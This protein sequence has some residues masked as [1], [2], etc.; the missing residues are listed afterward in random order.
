MNEISINWE[1]KLVNHRGFNRIA[2]YFE[3]NIAFNE[4][5][6]KIKGAKWSSSLKAWHIPDNIT[7][8][9]KFNLNTQKENPKINI[10]NKQ[11]LADLEQQLTLKAYSKSTITT[12]LAELTQFLISIKQVDAKDFTIERIKDYLQYCLQTLKLSE[13]TLHSRINALKFYYEQVLGYEKFFFDIPRPKKQ[14]QNPNFFNQEEITQI[15]NK[16]ENLKHKTMLMLAYSTGL[17]VSEIVNLKVKNID[18]QRMQIKVV[19]A[20]GKKD[21]MVA[22]SPILLV[23][24]RR[25]FIEYKPDLNGFLFEGVT[26]NITYS[27]RSL[28]LVLQAA[29]NRAGILKPGSIHALRHS[30]ATHLMDKGTDIN[31][32]MKLLGHNDIKTTLRYLH[33]TNRDLLNVI[34]PLDDLNLTL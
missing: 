7:N 19:Q 5:I 14:L 21:R 32:I 10:I 6:K 23:M 30:F 29:K 8:R 22:L 24:L 4:R 18:E 1:T 34:S 15:I 25:Y 28:Q 33:V 3:N 16:T 12:Y 13:A 9:I 20:K 11:A 31:M 2:I 17:R 27:T 26:K